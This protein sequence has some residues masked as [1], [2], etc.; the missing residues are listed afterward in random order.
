MSPI[1]PGKSSPRRE[2]WRWAGWFALS[3]G[4]LA[5]LIALRFVPYV[6]ADGL[7]TKAFM[8]LA[9]P[10]HFTSLAALMLLVVW[11]LTLI[12]GRR[13]LIVPLAFAIA[14]V[15]QLLLLIDTEVFAQY[16]FHL[17][18]FIFD[19]L[20]H[21]G[22]EIFAFGWETW[23]IAAAV[24]AVT[25]A[26]EL[27][28]VWLCLRLARRKHH[29]VGW[30]LAALV[31]VA[32]FGVHGWHAYADARYDRDVTALDHALPFYY[33]ATAKRFF[34]RHGLI[35]LQAMRNARSDQAVARA[36]VGGALDYPRGDLQCAP[37][38]QAQP[39]LLFVTID[40][41]RADTMNQE[42]TPHIAR[43]A[44]RP[45]V[46]RFTHHISGGNSTKAGIFSLFYGLPV[47][48]WEAFSAAQ[49]PP[50]LIEQLQRNGYDIEALGSA[51][52]ASPAF[53]RTVFSSVERLRTETPGAEPWQRDARITRDFL[54]YLDHHDSRQ[55]FFGFLFFD[56][57]HGY[58]VPPGFPHPFKPYWDEV[59][60][61]K[62]GPGFDP[63]PF[64]NRYRTAAR[65]V[66]GLIGQ[67]I[68]RLEA[69]GMLD[70]TVIVITSDHGEEFNDNG[71]NFWGHGSNYTDAQ[72]HVP[73]LL[74]WPGRVGG[75]I[76]RTTSHMDVAP[77]LMQSLLNCQALPQA[78]A[79]GQSLFSAQEHRWLLIGSYLD[80]AVRSR[81][82]IFEAYP[83]GDY[84]VFDE[85]NRP[86]KDFHLA[87]DVAAQIIQAMS[88]YYR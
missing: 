57:A 14:L 61:L 67:V 50:V 17:S 38:Q 49:H 46:M 80:Y 66:D 34:A 8:T 87:P 26:V 41:W 27:G 1:A 81:G 63:T 15:G 32:Q 70:N 75:T 65:Y 44:Q 71:L 86:A 85:H 84:D 20:I 28:L 69:R 52:L 74:Y 37:A 36:I 39:N 40:A 76:T 7:E 22:S 12:L 13:W 5:T 42:T 4:L 72:T 51:T 25:S 88:R 56:A 31:V 33:P 48:Y 77:T 47:T 68:D 35:D 6:N 60:H 23:L 79:I 3:N 64:Y 83:A 53:D 43:F 2:L 54:D 30:G 9:L 62:L 10:A 18:G 19:L 73:F 21:A 58:S 82:H 55:P 29:G 11:P 24:V 78:Y 16:R 45:D 59:D